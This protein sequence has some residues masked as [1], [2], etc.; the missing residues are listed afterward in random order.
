MA[1]ARD[2]QPYSFIRNPGIVA[3]VDQVVQHVMAT[4]EKFPM[5]SPDT[6][7]SRLDVLKHELIDEVCRVWIAMM[8]IAVADEAST[9]TVRRAGVHV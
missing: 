2:M 4:G 7:T 9:R 6:V 8:L 1:C 3:F 5:P